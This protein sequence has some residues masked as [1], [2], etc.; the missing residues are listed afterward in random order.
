MSDLTRYWCLTDR[1][2]AEEQHEMESWPA[3]WEAVY[4]AAEVE[5]LRAKVEALEQERDTIK[6]NMESRIHLHALSQNGIQRQLAETHA[7]LE[8]Q[9]IE[10]YSAVKRQ[11]LAQQMVV[12]QE[13]IIES[14][15]REVQRYKDL[16]EGKA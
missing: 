1:L 10:T 5:M 3:S 2:F 6:Q 9:R 4:K 13:S 7:H 15:Q 16:L 14:Q 11:Q 8:A 12:T